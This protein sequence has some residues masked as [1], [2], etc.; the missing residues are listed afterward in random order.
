MDDPSGLAL[1]L[2]NFVATHLPGRQ[3]ALLALPAAADSS[4]RQV[5]QQSTTPHALH[6]LVGRQSEAVGVVLGFFGGAGGAGQR[7]L[8]EL[9]LWLT[10]QRGVRRLDA[11]ASADARCWALLVVPARSDAL[12][13][14]NR[15]GRLEIADAACALVTGCG[16]GGLGLPAPDQPG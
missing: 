9:H 1:A 6:T 10:G 15:E 8:Q 7:F 5:T 2:A 3:G 13:Q 12:P 14:L 16:P 11:A 4:R